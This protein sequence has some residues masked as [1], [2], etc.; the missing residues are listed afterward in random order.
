[1]TTLLLNNFD[2]EIKPNSSLLS[3]WDFLSA[4]KI[5]PAYFI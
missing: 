3:S 4:V 5:I 1:M 2:G